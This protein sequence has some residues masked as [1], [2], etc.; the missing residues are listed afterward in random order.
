MAVLRTYLEEIRSTYL[1]AREDYTRIQDAIDAAEQKWKKA[2]ADVSLSPTGKRDAKQ[3]RD[4]SIR[5]LSGELRTL[6][7]NTQRNFANTRNTVEETYRSM[8]SM[9]PEKIDA[10]GMEL[11]RSGILTDG[12]IKNLY[13]KYNNENNYTML[14]MLA[15]VVDERLEKDKYN[16]ELRNL[17]ATIK[18]IGNPHLEAVD[19]YIYVCSMGLREER[20]AS[21]N[22]DKKMGDHTYEQIMEQY[23][24]ISAD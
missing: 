21:D 3:K 18:N 12:D 15:K 19:S 9:V 4:E 20:A 5:A 23:G 22:I 2:A 1:K 14:R 10:N 13:H 24:S 6:I 11:L 7:E 17:S 8:Y 16:A